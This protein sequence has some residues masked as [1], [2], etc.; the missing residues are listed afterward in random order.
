MRHL[1]WHPTIMSDSQDDLPLP[2]S[3]RSAGS[4]RLPPRLH[5][6]RAPELF[7]EEVRRRL[8]NIETSMRQVQDTLNAQQTA[9][10]EI[11]SLLESLSIASGHPSQHTISSY[12][13]TS[14]TTWTPHPGPASP[15]K[16]PSKTS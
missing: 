5:V 13:H 14:T 9:I 7:E 10:G 8:F 6:S 4:L 12:R 11:K 3:S 2:T 16:S 15:K 1:V